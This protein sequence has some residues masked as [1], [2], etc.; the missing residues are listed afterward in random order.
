MRK[1][2][3]IV[4]NSAIALF[5]AM[6]CALA[7]PRSANS[8][9]KVNGGVEAPLSHGT[10]EPGITVNEQVNCRSGAHR[11]SVSLT[12]DFGFGRCASPAYNDRGIKQNN[13]L[14]NRMASI[15]QK[16]PTATTEIIMA[17]FKYGRI[18]NVEPELLLAIAFVESS[19]RPNVVNHGCY[20]I[21][22][23]NYH[24][25]HK[26]MSLNPY[27][28]LEIDYNTEIACKILKH[29]ITK[30]GDVWKAVFRYNNGYKYRNMN[31]VPKVRK[32]Y[33]GIGGES[34]K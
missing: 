23:I 12:M 22:Q 1:R 5:A 13:G 17:A 32:F 10:T 4:C 29:Y 19:F 8:N 20:G 3:D 18:Y 16:C 24:V 2:F 15:S 21:Y 11:K 30:S 31:Y 25:W 9:N 26:V 7:L 33:R 27:K 6:V 14:L 34:E 28:L